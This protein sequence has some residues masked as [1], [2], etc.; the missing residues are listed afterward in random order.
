MDVLAAAR[1]SFNRRQ[2]GQSR[3][4]LDGFLQ[5]LVGTFSLRYFISIDSYFFT[6][7]II[8]R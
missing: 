7:T 6:M 8:I 4:S 3:N 2:R 5:E 1:A